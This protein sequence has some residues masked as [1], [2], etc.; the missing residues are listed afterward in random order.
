MDYMQLKKNVLKRIISETAQ[1]AER[2]ALT[3]VGVDSLGTI[4]VL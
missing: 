2:L 3:W 4:V 1:G